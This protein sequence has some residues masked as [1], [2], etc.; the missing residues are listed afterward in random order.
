MAERQPQPNNV[1]DIFTRRSPE[2][3]KESQMELAMELAHLDMEL[4][5]KLR[6]MEDI[7]R[8]LGLLDDELGLDG[9]DVS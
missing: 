3:S 4:E 2:L 8:T 1:I 6:R 5:P 9:G 7:R